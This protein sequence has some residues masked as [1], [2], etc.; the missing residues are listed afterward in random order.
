MNFIPISIGLDY[1]FLK[2]RFR[3][4]LGIGSVSAKAKLI[5]ASGNIYDGIDQDEL[6]S[7]SQVPF[8]E[9]SPGFSYRSGKNVQFGLNCDYVQSEDIGDKIGGFSKYSGIKI[10]GM[11]PVVF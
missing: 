4:Y 3:P 7:S 5:E 9:I 8:I 2:R 10:T 1:Y 11:F 6:E